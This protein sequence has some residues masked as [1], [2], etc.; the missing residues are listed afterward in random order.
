M[1]NEYIQHL[2]LEPKSQSRV[3]FDSVW[4]GLNYRAYKISIA[5]SP[6][7]TLDLGEDYQRGKHWYR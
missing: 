5:L 1:R 3:K 7:I 2:T 4:A 6:K